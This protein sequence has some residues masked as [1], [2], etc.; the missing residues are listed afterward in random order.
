MSASYAYKP[1]SDLLAETAF[2]SAAGLALKRAYDAARLVSIQ[3]NKPVPEEVQALLK[4]GKKLL[5]GGFR[6]TCPRMRP[7]LEQ[8]LTEK[9][10]RCIATY[11]EWVR[12]SGYVGYAREIGQ[13]LPTYVDVNLNFMI[14]KRR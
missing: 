5:R 13:G 3:A 14:E 1:G 12:S 9:Y 4:T 11:E 6:Y 7:G 2:N 10:S 8:D